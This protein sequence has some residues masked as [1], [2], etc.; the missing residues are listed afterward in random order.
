MSGRADELLTNSKF[1]LGNSHWD[2]DA[3]KISL[4]DPADANPLAPPPASSTNIVLKLKSGEWTKMSQD[5]ESPG[6]N[7]V[8]KV[9]YSV[10][11]D[12]TLSHR[13]ADFENLPAS[14]D[15]GYWWAFSTQPGN[16][17]I[18]LGDYV[19]RNE[20]YREIS[21]PKI[22]SSGPQTYTHPITAQSGGKKTLYLGFPPGTGT[23][24]FQEISLTP[25]SQ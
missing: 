3:E 13:S 5:F 6:G 1:D 24:T 12:F 9:T 23:I 8:I 19:A 7:M 21:A 10:S 4:P 20:Q 11:S 25:A 22:I 2:G 17:V 15:A 16:W 18:M 14:I